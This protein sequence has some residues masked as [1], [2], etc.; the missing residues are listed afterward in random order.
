MNVTG[1]FRWRSGCGEG[2]IWTPHH[3]DGPVYCCAE[4][5]GGRPCACA[6][7]SDRPVRLPPRSAAPKG[8][9]HAPAP[10][11]GR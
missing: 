3:T 7:G 8:G 5:A 4:C 11:A 2:A 9:Y 1:K 6:G 10:I